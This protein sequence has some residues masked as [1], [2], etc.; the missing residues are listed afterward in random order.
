M[1]ATALAVKEYVTTV[2]GTTS[3]QY[4]EVY[5]IKFMNRNI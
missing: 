4:K 2:F 1:V 3:L 5:R